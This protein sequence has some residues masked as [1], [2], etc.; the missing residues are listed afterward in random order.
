MPLVRVVIPTFNRASLLAEG[1]ETILL[2]SF[3]D[4]EIMVVDDGSTDNTEAVLQQFSVRDPRIRYLKQSNCG[5]SRARNNAI[6]EPGQ[7]SYIAFLDSDDLWSPRHLEESVTVLQRESKAA[8]VFSPVETVNIAGHLT[9]DKIRDRDRC[10]HNILH[11]S[12]PSSINGVYILDASKCFRAMLRGEFGPHPSTVV[13]RREAVLRAEWFNPDLEIFEDVEF[14]LHLAAR[15]LS[16]AYIESASACVRYYGDNLTGSRDLSSP[17]TLRRQQSVLH[18]YKMKMSLCSLPE[19]SRSVSKAI[20]ETAY[21]IGQCY[22]EL[23]D[24]SS[25]RHAYLDALHYQFSYKTIKGLICTLLPVPI[26]SFLKKNRL[27]LHKMFFRR[28][29]Y[30]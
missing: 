23:S 17:I 27:I 6:R 21:L 30:R 10:W 13:V 14:F 7:Y 18:Y 4:F 9:P 1:L 19:D 5:P 12:T 3:S 22:S 2:Q 15:Y 24:L 29:K 16:F 28:R 20:A 8:L 11:Y 26:F 25:A